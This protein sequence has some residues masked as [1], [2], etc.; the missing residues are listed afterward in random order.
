MT[1]AQLRKL[2]ENKGMSQRE[3][4]RRLGV[5]DRTVRYWTS[6]RDIPRVVELAILYVM[7]RF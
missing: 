3:L 2:L 6:G 7:E 4:S 1:S 5:H